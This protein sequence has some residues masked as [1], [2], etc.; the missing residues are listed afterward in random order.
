MF[1]IWFESKDGADISVTVR[2]VEDARF[3]WD[4]LESTG[5]RMISTRP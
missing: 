3:V 1:V 4:T 5:L 2:G